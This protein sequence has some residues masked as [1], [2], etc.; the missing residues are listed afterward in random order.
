MAIKIKSTGNIVDTPTGHPGS[1]RSQKPRRK[2]EKTH[3]TDS[4]PKP[5]R[6]H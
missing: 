3:G 5:A 6:K 2:A 1:K 4:K